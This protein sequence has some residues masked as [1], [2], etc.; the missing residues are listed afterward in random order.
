MERISPETK[1]IYDLLRADFDQA[2]DKAHRD[3]V[4]STAQTLAKLDQLSGRIDEV[5]LSIGVDLGELRQG[6]DR[7]SPTT[8]QAKGTATPPS[9]ASAG[10]PSGPD[11]HRVEHEIRGSGHKV[12]VPP[13]VRGMQLDQTHVRSPLSS[14]ENLHQSSTDVFGLGPRIELPRFD[15]SNPKL[16]QSRC[17]DYFKLWTTPQSLWISYA[18]SLF[19][20]PAARWLESVHR[21]VPLIQWE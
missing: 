17:E 10:G 20:G 7:S 12:Y 18:S 6:L 8:D 14:I 21:R 5:K 19:E 16:W 1:A 2:L 15:G 11:G 9:S 13:P 3:R 4:D